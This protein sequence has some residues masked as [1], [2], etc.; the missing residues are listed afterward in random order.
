ML[1][2]YGTAKWSQVS[3][4]P[5]EPTPGSQPQTPE[6]V[7]GLQH[8]VGVHLAMSMAVTR[9]VLVVAGAVLILACGTLVTL[10]LVIFGRRMTLRQVNHG[11]AQ[12]S[13]QLQQLQSGR[14]G[15]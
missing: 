11:L 3:N 13:Q 8:A 14:S 2:D 12:I 6:S 9:G 10:V 7:A 1:Q 5:V 4:H 15:A